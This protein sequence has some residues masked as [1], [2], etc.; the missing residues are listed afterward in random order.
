M[1]ST[2]SPASLPRTIKAARVHRFGPPEAIVIEDV[3]RPEPG[4]GQVLI[5]VAAAGVGPW[6]GWIRAGRSVLPQ[7]LPLTLGSDLSGTVAAVGPGVTGF[8]PGDEVFGVTNTR[9]TDAYAQYAIAAAGMIARKPA[10]IGHIDAASLPVVAVTAWQTLFGQA[11][12]CQ[13]QTVLILGG[14]GNVGTYAVQIAHRAGA[15]VI[16]TAST[17]DLDYVRSLGAD[18][19]VDRKERLED[20]VKAVDAVVDLVGGEAQASAFAVLKRGGV[21]V[22]AVSEPDQAE[23]AR[24]D[25]EA[26]FFLV[27]VNTVDLER[28]AAMV[29]TGELLSRIGTVLPLAEARTAH[30]MLDGTRPHPRGKIVLRIGS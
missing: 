8:A 25:V 11:R 18:E 4:E 2:A 13:G 30:E 16:A 14:A 21:L 5:R 17:G 1:T 19:A 24:R 3:E 12:I 10:R 26:G 15:R 28:I 27:Q 20:R 9:F 7:P 22:S 6:D 23:A 29:E